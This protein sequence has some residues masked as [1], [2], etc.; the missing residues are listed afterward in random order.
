VS[1]HD[2]DGDLEQVVG[3]GMRTAPSAPHPVHLLPMPD[4]AARML[5]RT[6][7]ERGETV[8]AVNGALPAVRRVAEELARLTGGRAEVHEHMRLHVLEELVEPRPVP[9]R[10]RRATTAD[11]ELAF[12]WFRAFHADAAAQ[13]GRGEVS[14]EQFTAD[15]VAVRIEPGRV[16]LWQDDAG[17]V[18]SLVAHNPPVSGVARI[19][20]VFTPAA[21]RGRGWAS[22]LTAH[23]SRLLADEGARVCLFTDQANPVSNH[24]YAALGYVP[25]VDTADL[26]VV[27]RLDLDE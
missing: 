22:A 10:A 27:P 9:G 6:L 1:V 13:A 14:P 15:D 3:A 23:V 2:G 20:P 19:G 25:V 5:A 26:Q 11:L 7:V 8:T 18:V 16:W 21:Q 24:V 4:E 17:E 12:A